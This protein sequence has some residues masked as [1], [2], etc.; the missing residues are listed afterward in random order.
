MLEYSECIRPIIFYSIKRMYSRVFI[1]YYINNITV[2][3]GRMA[4][5]KKKS[6]DQ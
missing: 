1:I 4:E 2:L 3:S 5:E 6:E